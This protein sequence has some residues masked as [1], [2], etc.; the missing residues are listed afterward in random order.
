MTDQF[1]DRSRRGDLPGLSSRNT[2]DDLI[3]D[4]SVFFL[5]DDDFQTI[6][7]D[8]YYARLNLS[9]DVRWLFDYRSQS[10]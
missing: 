9:P 10:G 3:A 6:F 8:D 2:T 1:T 5:D 7:Q 4:D